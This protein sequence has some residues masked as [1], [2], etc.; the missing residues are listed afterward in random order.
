MTDTADNRAAWWRTAR[1]N[2]GQAVDAI[3]ARARDD[4]YA[5]GIA[6][7][8]VAARNAGASV[9]VRTA[10]SLLVGKQLPNETA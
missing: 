4:G 1:A 9:E 8:L 3:A 2:V 5:D 7:A 10:L 6:D